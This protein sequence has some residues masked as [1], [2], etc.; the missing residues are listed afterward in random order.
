MIT[1]EQ[2]EK[3]RE[4]GYEAGVAF[5]VPQDPNDPTSPRDKPVWFLRAETATHYLAEED[6]AQ[7]LIDAGP[8]ETREEHDAK[9]A[10]LEAEMEKQQ[11]AAQEALDA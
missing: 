2:V 6:Q 4:L 8:P 1:P 3:L 9:N 10:A 11:R 5:H 7:A